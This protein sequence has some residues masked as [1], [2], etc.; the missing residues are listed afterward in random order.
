[1]TDLRVG[2]N[3]HAMLRRVSSGRAA[4]LFRL[5][6]GALRGAFLAVWRFNVL[7]APPLLVSAVGPAVLPF[8]QLLGTAARLVCLTD[9]FIVVL[10]VRRV[11]DAVDTRFRRGFPPNVL[12]AV[13]LFLHLV[14][15]RALR[16]VLVAVA[17]AGFVFAPHASLNTLG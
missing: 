2:Y 10:A 6:T 3:P 4:R 13:A 15:H 11:R 14:E 1:M 7:A 17:A 5:E 12:R 8:A 16:P 9:A